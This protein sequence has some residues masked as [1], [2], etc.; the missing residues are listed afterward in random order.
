M[1]QRLKAKQKRSVPIPTL[2][3]R[4]STPREP[5]FKEFR[6]YSALHFTARLPPITLSVFYTTTPAPPSLARPHYHH[7]HPDPT[8]TP[9]PPTPPTPIPPSPTPAS[10]LECTFSSCSLYVING[11][12]VTRRWWRW[13]VGAGKQVEGVIEGWRK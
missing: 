1:A 3:S 12:T 5:L 9:P 8:T 13:S 11:C 2:H 4:L 7:H 10:A 6:T